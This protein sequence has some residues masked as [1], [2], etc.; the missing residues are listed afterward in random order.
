MS[1]VS[2][3]AEATLTEAELLD[4]V[5]TQEATYGEISRIGNE[6]GLTAGSFYRFDPAHPRP[7]IEAGME[8]LEDLEAEEHEGELCRGEVYIEEELQNVVVFRP[9]D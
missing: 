5:R 3:T 9:A 4:W 6:D 1:I 7:E 2:S 8:L